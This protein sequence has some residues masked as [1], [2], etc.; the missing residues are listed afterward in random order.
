MNS[1][2]HSTDKDYIKDTLAVGIWVVFVHVTEA[3]KKSNI[4]FQS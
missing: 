4:W 3:I 1:S 2:I